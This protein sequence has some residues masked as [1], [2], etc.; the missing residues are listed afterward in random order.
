MTNWPAYNQ[1]LRDIEAEQ[2]V[3]LLTWADVTQIFPQDF[4][5]TIRPAD[6]ERR[7]LLPA[8]AERLWLWRRDENKPRFRKVEVTAYHPDQD[9][10]DASTLDST[11]W[12]YRLNDGVKIVTLENGTGLR[13]NDI[14]VEAEDGHDPNNTETHFPKE[15]RDKLMAKEMR[16]AE[17]KAELKAVLKTSVKAKP[18]AVST[19]AQLE[20]QKAEAEAAVKNADTDLA[21][22]DEQQT[23]FV[24]KAL[25]Q[26]HFD[27]L[28]DDYKKYTMD[29]LEKAFIT[30]FIDEHVLTLESSG[31]GSDIYD[32]NPKM[33]KELAND[34][35]LRHLKDFFVAA[36]NDI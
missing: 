19:I 21:E 24:L 18:K 5:I 34:P 20:K 15:V 14:I 9:K 13:P 36:S 7:F 11:K 12:E 28:P 26:N 2:R 35:D 4:K 31:S 8:F 16:L 30:L 17:L 25:L 1:A 10:P 33:F 32:F 3:L 29:K 6:N 27:K 22:D 23:K